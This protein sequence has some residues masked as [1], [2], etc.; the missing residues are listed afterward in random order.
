MLAT[1]ATEGGG[2]K[3]RR[4]VGLHHPAGMRPA[5]GSRTLATRGRP[6]QRGI[7][8]FATG[9]S[10]SGTALVHPC[11]AR[12]RARPGPHPEAEVAVHLP[13]R[14]RGRG[15]TPVHPPCGGGLSPSFPSPPFGDGGRTPPRSPHLWSGFQTS[16]ER[17]SVCRRTIASLSGRCGCARSACTR[18]RQSHPH[19]PGRAPNDA[20]HKLPGA[21][22]G[23]GRAHPERPVRFQA[24]ELLETF[25][26]VAKTPCGRGFWS[27][28]QPPGV[29]WGGSPRPSPPGAGRGG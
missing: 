25:T 7:T 28:G 15:N 12:S 8:A 3:T 26:S 29:G 21:D 13:V 1:P 22:C 2:G 17:S 18:L 23:R 27:G 16:V 14:G 11:G 20:L 6:E 5:P 24:A 9:T 19:H 4:T 10:V